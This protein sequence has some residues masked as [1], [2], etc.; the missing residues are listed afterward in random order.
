MADACPVGGLAHVSPTAS[1]PTLASRRGS[2]RVAWRKR[3]SEYN[4][5]ITYCICYEIYII[6]L[7][8]CNSRVYAFVDAR[9]TAFMTKFW[10]KSGGKGKATNNAV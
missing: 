7:R 4:F 3:V 5:A 8:S 2:G 10:M 9:I 6:G 1:R